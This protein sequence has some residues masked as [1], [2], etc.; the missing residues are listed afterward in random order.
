MKDYTIDNPEFS[1]KVSVVETND[2]AHADVINTPIKQ[3]FGNTVA[4]MKELAKIN[5]GI[6]KLSGQITRLED[7][8]YNDI[9]G[10]PWVLTFEN[11]DGVELARGNYN[12]SEQWIEC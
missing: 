7:A 5:T 1:E 8:V 11:L 3:L 4:I 10:N 12:R 9:T 2:P 6:S